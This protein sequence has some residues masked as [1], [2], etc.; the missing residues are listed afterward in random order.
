MF[1]IRT[2]KV[3]ITRLKIRPDSKFFSKT[4]PQVRSLENGLLG[5]SKFILGQTPSIKA[6]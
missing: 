4:H 5:F 2:F 6:F 1:K 3:K